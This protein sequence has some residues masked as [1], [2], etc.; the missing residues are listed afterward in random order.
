[1]SRLVRPHAR[2]LASVLTLLLLAAATLGGAEKARSAPAPGHSA[3]AKTRGCKVKKG[4]KR[5]PSINTSKR[6]GHR[7]A[8]ANNGKGAGNPYAGGGCTAWAW[9]NRP[10][11]PG[12]LGNA[13]TWGD[14]AARAGFPVDNRPEV[15]AIAVYQPD[16]YGAFKPFGH[17]ALVTAV[18]PNRVQISE[19]SYPYDNI[20]YRGRWTGVVGVQFIHRKG[21]TGGATILAPSPATEAEP[22]PAPAPA[23]MTVGF[24]APAVDATVTG[25]LRISAN[26]SNTR[27]VIFSAYYATDPSDVST[28]AWH[29]LGADS[30]GA[31]GWSLD[32]DT[33]GIPDQSNTGW[34]TVNLAVIAMDATGAPSEVRAYRRVGIVNTISASSEANLLTNGSFEADTGCGTTAPT[35]WF[36]SRP[37]GFGACVYDDP[38]LAADGRRLLDVVTASPPISLAQDVPI[39]PRTGEEYRARIKVRVPPGDPDGAS[40]RLAVW[41]LDGSAEHAAT[42]FTATSSWQT[43]TAVLPVSHSDQSRLRIEL[44]FD[45]AA[46]RVLVDGASLGR[47]R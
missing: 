36:F 46:R 37:D 25:T 40:G 11:L 43:V 17:V 42:T 44:Y 41:A 8:D 21:Y 2:A 20:I 19:A 4:K 15:G 14:R 34:G 23:P 30:N 47:T 26:A 27:G 13:L 16:R 24:N 6:H 1:M 22:A 12:N 18:Q 7:L 10:D 35:A 3:T 29:A 33:R 39:V 28:V 38:P 31:D 9:A 45:S 5:C 32:W